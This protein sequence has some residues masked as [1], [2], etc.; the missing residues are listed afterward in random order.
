LILTDTVLCAAFD[1]ILNLEWF[2][3]ELVKMILEG[4]QKSLA[5]LLSHINVPR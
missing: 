4:Y 2:E 1:E 3:F 5:C